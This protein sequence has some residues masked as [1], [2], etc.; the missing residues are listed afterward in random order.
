MK[1]IS[2]VILIFVF[3]CGVLDSEDGQINSHPLIGSWQLISISHVEVKSPDS[4]EL[5]VVTEVLEEETHLT[6]DETKMIKNYT[7][8]AT[9]LSVWWDA[10]DDTITIYRAKVINGTQQLVIAGPLYGNKY[11][12][13]IEE[14]TLTNFLSYED[15][16][17]DSTVRY[18]LPYK[19]VR[20]K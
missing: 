2:L 6:Y 10:T 7:S 4:E 18:S 5:I 13:T 14:D 12:Y 15:I 20:I 3:S 16:G 11:Y 8:A 1:F 9:E 19:Y 17:T